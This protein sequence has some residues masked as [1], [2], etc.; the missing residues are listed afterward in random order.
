MWV[1]LIDEQ[2]R[3]VPDIP[4]VQTPHVLPAPIIPAALVKASDAS[5]S[6]AI[7]PQPPRPAIASPHPLPTPPALTP[8]MYAPP[9]PGLPHSGEHSSL[10]TLT[11]S[12]RKPITYH[13]L[14][15]TLP[16]TNIDID[17]LNIN[18]PI[19]SYVEGDMVYWYST[20]VPD[21]EHRLSLIE[22]SHFLS[23]DIAIEPHVHKDFRKALPIPEWNKAI[24]TDLTSKS[25]GRCQ[26]TSSC[27]NNQREHNLFSEARIVL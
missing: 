19:V 16:S 15:T 2:E 10:D 4:Q 7:E 26:D 8:P 18:T 3:I 22:K 12:Q 5:P 21:H 17:T 24:D 23:L 25:L 6:R 27:R 1:D 9:T 20:S 11:R 13:R 14:P